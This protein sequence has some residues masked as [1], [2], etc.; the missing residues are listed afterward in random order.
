MD[1]G[2]PAL[3]G[4]CGPC[5]L[6]RTPTC[7]ISPVRPSTSL[8]HVRQKHLCPRVYSASAGG[9]QTLSKDANARLNRGSCV[10]RCWRRSHSLP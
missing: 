2:R 4:L 5:R 10:G 7:V 9:R 6:S 3:R 1:K 8:G